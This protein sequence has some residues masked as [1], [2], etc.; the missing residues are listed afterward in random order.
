MATLATNAVQEMH[1]KKQPTP[2][3]TVKVCAATYSAT[4]RYPAIWFDT[5]ARLVSGGSVRQS[6]NEERLKVKESTRNCRCCRWWRGE[7]IDRMAGSGDH[8]H[9]HDAQSPE[10]RVSWRYHVDSRVAIIFCD[11]SM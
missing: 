6:T 7:A 4:F 10:S 1:V 2:I 8:G 3:K 5:C 9:C 11:H